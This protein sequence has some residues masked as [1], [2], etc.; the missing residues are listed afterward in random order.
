MNE[1]NGQTSRHM[2]YQSSVDPKNKVHT[3]TVGSVSGVSGLTRA[4]CQ[5]VDVTAGSIGMATTVV[6]K[7]W[8]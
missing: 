8:V 3:I 2:E 1:K 7:T 4:H 6:N 5:V